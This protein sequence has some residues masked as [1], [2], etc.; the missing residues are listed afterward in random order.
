MERQDSHQIKCEIC[1]YRMADRM[2]VLRLRRLGKKF[3]L[4]EGVLFESTRYLAVPDGVPRF[5]TQRRPQHELISSRAG[6]ATGTSNVR[7]RS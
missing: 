4:L 3:D 2:V 5:H 1:V 7:G 6:S